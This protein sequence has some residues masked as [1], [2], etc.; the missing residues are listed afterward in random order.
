MTCEVGGEKVRDRGLRPPFHEF[1]SPGPLPFCRSVPC[2]P[3]VNAL[4]G[5]TS[6]SSSSSP[7]PQAPPPPPHVAPAPAPRVSPVGLGSPAT[8]VR[9]RAPR[10]P[11][12]ARTRGLRPKGGRPPSPRPLRSVEP[13]ERDEC[14]GAPKF[15]RA[16]LFLA[17]RVRFGEDGRGPEA[18]EEAAE[19]GGEG[20]GRSW[21][22]DRFGGGATRVWREIAE[23]RT[24][25]H[26]ESVRE[27][28][29]VCARVVRSLFGPP[30]SSY[31]PPL[32]TSKPTYSAL[33]CQW[34]NLGV[35]L[36]TELD[37]D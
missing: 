11:E 26:L 15:C 8:V 30:T 29:N 22:R 14:S 25:K 36:P 5:V 19:E 21:G 3:F 17:S 1:F 20:G 31:T 33:Q 4:L 16:A 9:V 6:S 18:E 10:G 34:V 7:L 12:A 24:G 32:L 2:S 35:S 27:E 37:P 13:P 23:V 28:T